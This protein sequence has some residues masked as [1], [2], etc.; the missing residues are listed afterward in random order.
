MGDH[1]DLTIFVFD[2]CDKDGAYVGTLDFLNESANILSKIEFNH[3]DYF[4]P[5]GIHVGQN[6]KAVLFTVGRDQGYEYH[7]YFHRMDKNAGYIAE[8]SECTNESAF[9]K[10]NT[11]TPLL[12]RIDSSGSII[13]LSYEVRDSF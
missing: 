2:R 6:D 10:S 1:S 4:K 8:N 5:A 13:R 12:V 11:L 9:L 3:G 7:Y